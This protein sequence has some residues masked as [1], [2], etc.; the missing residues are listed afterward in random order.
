MTDNYSESLQPIPAFTDAALL[1][2][3]VAPGFIIIPGVT[4]NLL[5]KT[6]SHSCD[7]TDPDILQP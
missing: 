7:A 6:L 4:G 3:Q 5:G 2:N 1:V